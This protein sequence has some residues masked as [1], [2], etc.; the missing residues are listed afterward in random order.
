MQRLLGLVVGESALIWILHALRPVFPVNWP[1]LDI[2][3]R[4]T[5]AD[6]IVM[7]GVRYVALF[8]AYWLLASTILYALGIIGNLSRLTRSIEWA[9]VPAIRAI[10][11]KALAITLATSSFT[12]AA[13]I[14]LPAISVS[15]LSEPATA[16]E[17]AEATEVVVTIAEN[18]TILPP[19]AI[20]PSIAPPIAGPTVSTPLPSPVDQPISGA[21]ADQPAT[22]SP[23]HPLTSTGAATSAQYTVVRG[24]NLWDISARHLAAAQPGIELT[25]ADIATYWVQVIDGN[26]ATIASGNPDWISPGEVVVLPPIGERP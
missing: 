1:S 5:P 23:T 12:P 22:T 2:W 25:D 26:R 17:E 18:G 16:E 10:T 13:A 9:T 11:R 20:L 3:I 7:A 21:V 19:G 6:Q 14:M 15:A 4:F 8:F 24:D